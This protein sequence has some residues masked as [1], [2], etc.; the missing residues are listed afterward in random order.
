MTRRKG[1]VA[2]QSSPKKKVAPRSPSTDSIKKK[3]TSTGPIKGRD[4]SQSVYVGPTKSWSKVIPKKRKAQAIVDTDSYVEVDVQNISPRKKPTTSKLAASVPEVPIDNISFHYPS[5]V[6]RWKYVFHKRIALERE[7]TRDVLENKEIMDLIHEAGLLK[8]VVHLPTCYEILVK[9]FIVNLSEDCANRKSKDFG[10]VYV[11]GKCVTFSSTVINNFLGRSDE[12]RPELEVTDNKICEVITAKQVKAWPLKGKLFV[13]KLSI[14]YAMLHKIGAANWVPKNHKSTVAIVLGKFIYVVGTKNKFD[15]G[16]YIFDQTMKHA[17]SYS[18]KGL[19]AFPSIICGI[20]VNRYPN[21]LSENDSVCKRESAISF[22][23][24][25]FQGTHVPDIVTTSA[26]TSK[27]STTTRK[28]VVIAMLRE[29]CKELESI[30]L[31]LERLISSLE[32]NEMN[33]GAEFDDANMDEQGEEEGESDREVEKEASQDNGTDKDA[34]D[35]ELSSS[36]D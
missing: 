27:D 36:K 10:K 30:K 18:V 9:E 1:N 34:A 6:N 33:E 19:I 22:H 11:R 5:S 35:V 24:K 25:L 14:K 15:Y 2:V 17:G 26:G 12:A 8:T 13:S 21:I 7:L 16:T 31:A 28:V 3:N 20:I 29:T 4:V 32:M 23:Y